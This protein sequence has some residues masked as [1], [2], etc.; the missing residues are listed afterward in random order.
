V[1]ACG[2]FMLSQRA[3]DGG[4]I[5]TIAAVTAALFATT[6]IVVRRFTRAER[7]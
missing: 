2:V 7:A 3:A 6:T 5:V 1:V 4:R